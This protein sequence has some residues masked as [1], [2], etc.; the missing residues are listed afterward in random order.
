MAQPAAIVQNGS[1]RLYY[2]MVITNFNKNSYVLDAIEAKAGASQ[3]RYE[4]QSLA[5]MIDRLGGRAQRESPASGIEGGRG[6]IVFLA[7]DLGEGKAPSTIEHRLSVVDDNGEA[8]EIVLAPLR[9][10]QESPIVI[11]PPLQGEWI[12]GDSANN[13]PDAAHRRA[14]LIDNGHAWLAQ[15]YAIDW[16]QYQTVDGKRTTWKGPEDKNESYFCYNQPIY[17]VAAGR[18]VDASDG[19]AENV[20]HSGKY[21]VPIDFNNAAGNHVVVEIAPHRFV[22]YAHMRPGSLPVK[23]GD[24]VEVRQIIGRV[25]NTGSSSEPHLHMHIDD[26]PSFLAGNGVP[27]EFMNGEASGPVEANV[28]SPD[29]IHFG[30]IGPQKPFSKDY[31]AENAAVTFR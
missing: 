20:P 7:L 21:A 27:Y 25:G 12:A 31:P 26:Q 18:V 10:S 17:S 28:S 5:A 13:R 4:G 23:T 1:T 6:I 29:A 11:A 19:M 9:V 8:H 22:L 16:V 24:S 30:P 3:I 2:E 14:V 15:R